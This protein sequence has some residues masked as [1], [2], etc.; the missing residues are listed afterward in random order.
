[1][2]DKGS[3]KV[4]V[5]GYQRHVGPI[6]VVAF[7]LVVSLPF[8]NKAFHIDDPLYLSIARQILVDPLRPY[9]GLINW[10]QVTQ[11][12]WFVSI[13]PPGYS[14]WLA[15]W[16]AVG[17]T[18]EWG[19]HCAATIW[20]IILG[21][22]VYCWARRL[23]DQPLA[24]TLLVMSSPLVI[25]GRNLM[26]DVPM[27]ALAAGSMVVYQWA[28]ERRSMGLAL[29]AGLLAGLCVNVKYAGVVVLGVML[30]DSVLWRRWRLLPASLLGVALL[31]IGQM[32]IASRDGTPQLIFARKWIQDQWPSGAGDMAHRGLE[33]IVYLGGAAAWF[34]M[35][36][37]LLCRRKPWSMVIA[38]VAIAAGALAAFDVQARESTA[39]AAA[40][41][42]AGLFACNGALIVVWAATQLIRASRSTGW[43]RLKDAWVRNDDSNPLRQSIMLG[44]WTAGF[45]YFGT[46]NGPFVAPRALLP[47]VMSLALAGMLAMSLDLPGKFWL[48]GSV[49][50]TLIAGLLV[51]VADY[52]W[53]GTYRE[54]APRL[55]EQ[56]KQANGGKLY[57]FGHWGWQHYALAA[58][59]VQFDPIRARPAAGDAIIW[60]RNVDSALLV[61]V[62]LRGTREI[63]R[64]P[65]PATEWLPR[66]RSREGLIFLHGDT[67]NGRI[68]W[69]WPGTPSPQE[70]FVILRLGN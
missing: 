63:A 24:I 17:V 33:S 16:M 47:C 51:G 69:G 61:E 21:L 9:D 1:M 55:A 53:A 39:G 10:Q 3:E 26:L 59:L 35:M 36:G 32:T 30:I 6:I 48:R 38:V 44:T 8:C 70:I 23:G 20:V 5:P 31:V 64:E 45:W 60:P 50:L 57:F 28:S 40:L 65:V 66:T 54:Y 18:S 19:L 4:H 27:A 62:M 25:A 7:S 67:E 43:S 42:Q 29:L 56:Y 2:A 15:A 58:G 12:A 34:F 52:Q 49:A 22:A 11:P 41:V 14:Y 68:P 13:S 46:L 37:S